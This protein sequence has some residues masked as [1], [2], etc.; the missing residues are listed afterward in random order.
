MVLITTQ[1]PETLPVVDKCTSCVSN[2]NSMEKAFEV[3]WTL[4]VVAGSKPAARHN[5]GGAPLPQGLGSLGRWN[6]L[7]YE[8]RIQKADQRVR[9][10]INRV[11]IETAENFQGASIRLIFSIINKHT[12]GVERRRSRSNVEN[13]QT[14]LHFDGRGR[15]FL[16]RGSEGGEQ[17]A[18]HNGRSFL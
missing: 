18:S 15:G 3:R 13:S 7:H 16:A 14:C 11:I 6:L 8:N 12:C 2:R 1:N 4:L 17:V 5:C 10:T 9:P